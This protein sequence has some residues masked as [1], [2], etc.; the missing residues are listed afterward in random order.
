LLNNYVLIDVASFLYH[1]YVIFPKVDYSLYRI[2]RSRNI[3]MI[4][5][6][7]KLLKTINYVSYKFKRISSLFWTKP[8]WCLSSIPFFVI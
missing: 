3:T 6:L 2:A 5:L 7:S 4:G 1:S 8:N